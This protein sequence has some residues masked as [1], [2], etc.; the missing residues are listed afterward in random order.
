MPQCFGE[1][2][3]QAEH[4]KYWSRLRWYIARFFIKRNACIKERSRGYLTMPGS[5]LDSWLMGDKDVYSFIFA[6]KSLTCPCI[7]VKGRNYLF[8][9]GFSY[10]LLEKGKTEVTIPWNFEI[11]GEM[12]DD[13]YEPPINESSR[14]YWLS[15]ENLSDINT[16][17]I[18]EERPTTQ[19]TEEHPTTQITE[20]RPKKIS[21]TDPLYFFTSKSL[22]GGIPE[23]DGQVIPYMSQLD[24]R[25]K[26]YK[27]DHLKSAHILAGEKRKMAQEIASLKKKAIDVKELKAQLI[28]M[29]KKMEKAKNKKTTK[30]V[31]NTRRTKNN[32]LNALRAECENLKAQIDQFRHQYPIP[33]VVRY[34]DK[35]LTSLRA[36]DRLNK[37]AELPEGVTPFFPS[38]KKLKKHRLELFDFL[39]AKIGVEYSDDKLCAWFDY[40]KVLEL[41]ICRHF[42]YSDNKDSEGNVIVRLVLTMDATRYESHSFSFGGFKII[43][44]QSRDNCFILNMWEGRDNH[45][46]NLKYFAKFFEW[47]VAKHNTIFS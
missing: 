4:K 11:P 14:P 1:Y 16:T 24:M 22:G 13:A 34:I 47:G 15:P 10:I 6:R 28:V 40:E 43:G 45:E 44:N 37:L 29:N 25:D 32:Q 17:Q 27:N 18:T 19:I 20:E 5:F 33:K 9:I 2:V 36:I 35:S 23:A 46:N 38:T 7:S 30:K 8:Y 41:M 31:Y 39:K 12:C 3:L 26:V 21:K 42:K